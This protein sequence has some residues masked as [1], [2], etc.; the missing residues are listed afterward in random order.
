MNKFSLIVAD[1]PMQYFQRSTQFVIEIHRDKNVASF[2][3]KV[4]AFKPKQPE[5][6]PFYHELVLLF[7]CR[8][9]KF[10]D[11]DEKPERLLK[12]F[13]EDKTSR[14]VCPFRVSKKILF[15]ILWHSSVWDIYLFI[16][17]FTHFLAPMTQTVLQNRSFWIQKVPKPKRSWD[18]AGSSSYRSSEKYVE[19]LFIKDLKLSCYNLSTLKSF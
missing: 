15:L 12:A 17:L 13:G 9:C 19:F 11:Q 10:I 4:N 5:P 18:R 6:H 1:V 8:S 7:S 2:G 3:F 14:Y 16:H